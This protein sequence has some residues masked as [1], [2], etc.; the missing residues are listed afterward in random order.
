MV[1]YLFFIRY[2]GESNLDN[3]LNSLPN[4]NDNQIIVS[5]RQTFHETLLQM[6]EVSSTRKENWIVAVDADMILVEDF[7]D[8]VIQTIKALES[9]K[10]IMHKLLVFQGL[11]ACNL[12]KKWRY[13]MH[14]YYNPNMQKCSNLLYK[15]VNEIRPESS[16]WKLCNEQGYYTVCTMEKIAYHQHIRS[17]EEA[18]RQGL[19]QAEKYRSICGELFFKNL[20]EVS[21]ISGLLMGIKEKDFPDLNLEIQINSKN[22]SDNLGILSISELRKRL[23]DKCKNWPL[24][25]KVGMIRPVP[26]ASLIMLFYANYIK[27]LE[28]LLKSVKNKKR[29]LRSIQ[30]FIPILKR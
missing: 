4:L 14:I 15:T 9:N 7:V 28:K 10:E 27:L 3:C 18:F 16:W 25:N 11:V 19:I 1:D 21:F 12:W 5:E 8:V 23:F 22:N 29:K 20:E 30:K 26:K 13:G 17:N 6:I 2:N 24:D